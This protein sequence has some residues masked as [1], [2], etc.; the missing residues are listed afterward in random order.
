M[1]EL[2]ASM[3]KCTS[4][5]NKYLLCFRITGVYSKWNSKNIVRIKTEWE[6]FRVAMSWQWIF[7]GFPSSRVSNLMVLLFLKRRKVPRNNTKIKFNV[8]TTFWLIK[9]Y[10]LTPAFILVVRWS[11]LLI[12]QNSIRMWSTIN[13]TVSRLFRAFQLESRF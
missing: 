12:V 11:H 5:E 8:L 13:N 9:F 1:D 3:R 7:H 2:H 4:W 10:L 6:K